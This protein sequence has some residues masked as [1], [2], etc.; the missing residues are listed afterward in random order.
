MHELPP[1]AL[2][3]LSNAPLDEDNKFSI[4]LEVTSNS[5]AKGLLRHSCSFYPIDENDAASIQQPQAKGYFYFS[6]LIVVWP[7]NYIHR[8][9]LV[10]KETI[11]NTVERSIIV[12]DVD[13]PGG[14]IRGRTIFF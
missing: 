13:L 7:G 2:L 12:L 5:P 14:Q 6:P 1:F 9:H 10:V 8:F 4:R 11:V 3:L